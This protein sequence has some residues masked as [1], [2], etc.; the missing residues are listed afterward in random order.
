MT[1]T[2]RITYTNDSSGMIDQHIMDSQGTLADVNLALARIW[3]NVHQAINPFVS[4]TDVAL[5]DKGELVMTTHILMSKDTYCAPTVEKHLKD[6]CRHL[7][8][9]RKAIGNDLGIVGV[10]RIIKKLVRVLRGLKRQ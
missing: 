6:Y 8:C 2:A 4:T 7:F 10:H 5:F 3:L 9:R 1:I